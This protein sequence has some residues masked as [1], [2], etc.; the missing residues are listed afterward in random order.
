M[1]YVGLTKEHSSRY[2]HEFSGGQRQRIGIARALAT[3]PDFIICD[4]AV[5]ALDVSVRA[6]II[7]TLTDLQKSFSLTYLFI[8]H[9]L[10]IVRHISDEIAVMYLGKIVEYGSCASVY[11]SPLHP[12]TKALIAAIPKADPKSAKETRKIE[13]SYDIP[14]PTEIPKGCAFRT[15]C[16]YKRKLCE[17][18]EPKLREIESGHFSSCH[19][20]EDVF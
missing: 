13:I 14:S 10:L 11:E 9:D 3:N 8:A 12:Y 16:P 6:Q 5:S 7:N 19:Y 1:S 2:P 20:A 4:E 15:R 18:S 17:E